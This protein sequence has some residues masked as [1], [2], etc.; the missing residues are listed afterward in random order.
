MKIIDKLW[1][2]GV[3]HIVFTGGEPTQRKDLPELIAHAEK[4][5]QITGLITNGRRLSDPKYLDK[6]VKAGLDHVQITLESFNPKTHDSITGTPGSWKETVS[7][8]QNAQKVDIYLSTNSTVLQQNKNEMVE[9]IEFI[10]GLGVVNVSLNG[11]IRSG[12]G[13]ESEAVTLNEISSLLPQV[14]EIAE[15]KK[16]NFIWYT[17]TPYCELNP[18]N[19]DL[20]IK[21]CTAC[22]INMAVEPNGDVLPCQSYYKPLGN[23][24]SDPWEKLWNNDECERFRQREYAPEKCSSCTLLNLCGGACPLSWDAGD[25]I[26]MDKQS[27]G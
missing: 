3:P 18:V 1:E 17:P 6:L 19:M 13:K 2:I 20:G 26:C 10:S 16:L 7:G 4:K 11:L 14:K 12:S 23:L 22:T 21:Q 25:Y 8:I 27:S 24:L 15:D 5:G 9:T